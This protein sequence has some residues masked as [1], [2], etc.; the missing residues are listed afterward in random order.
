MGMLLRRFLAVVTI[1][2]TATAKTA[3]P[4]LNPRQLEVDVTYQIQARRG[5]TLCFKLIGLHDNK[6]F[7]ARVSHPASVRIKS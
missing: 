5:E 3:S 7:E 4:S 2:I 1:T 6:D